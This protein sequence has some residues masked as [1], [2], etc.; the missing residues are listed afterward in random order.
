[1]SSL[2]IV[3][4]PSAYAPN[5]GGIEELTR[6]LA[7][8]LAQR[9]HRPSV[10]TNRW[11]E[12]LPREERNAGVDVIRLDFPLPAMSIV[13]GARFLATG[14][15]AVARLLRALRADRP[16]VIHVIGAGPQSA[17]LAGLRPFISSRVVFTAQGELT[18]DAN[19]VFA[20]SLSLR[21][22]LRTMLARADAVTACSAHVLRELATVRAI[23]S[24]AIVIPN[25]VDP[26]EFEPSARR[27]TSD[28]FVLAVGR[29]V[30]QKGFDV[31]LDAAAD[32]RL[33]K[34]R[35][36]IAGD[37]PQRATLQ[38]QAEELGIS[39]RVSFFGIASRAQLKELFRDS[40]AFAMPSRGEPF[41]IVLLEAMAAGVPAVATAAGG[42]PEFA[43]DGENALLV[44]PDSASALAVALARIL[45][46]RALRER[47]AANGRE[48]AE[49]LSWNGIAERYE[50]VYNR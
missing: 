13:G 39:D 50:Q 42:I 48:T 34:T 3:L 38:R 24:S 12:S 25:G 6:Q 14:G 20:N 33:A 5:V 22:G 28:P 49:A 30:P 26:A 37:G 27:V 16:D 9:G 31:L 7:L 23:D 8:R 47:L 17:Y 41:G 21:L 43:R 45:D 40:A 4:A 19:D 29:L 1:M 36:T 32:P 35:F 15:G 46:D 2:R 44:P 18:F 10:L 11:P